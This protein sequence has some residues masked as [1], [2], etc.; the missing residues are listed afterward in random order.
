[1]RRRVLTLLVVGLMLFATACGN[2]S[3]GSTAEF[4]ATTESKSSGY[5]SLGLS[6]S[7]SEDSIGSGDYADY[8]E[9]DYESDYSNDGGSEV[10]L[11]EYDT[12]RKLIY[13]SYINLESKKFDEDVDAIKE[14]VSAN[15]G[16]FE[17]TSSYGNEEYGSRSA[18][19]TAR[20]PSDKYEAFMNS[21]GEVGSLASKS[22]SVDDIT[23]SY[24]D[25]QARLKS[26]NTKLE[27][28][29]E[30]EEQADNLED[31]LAIEDRINDVQYQIE[32]YTAQKKAYDDQIDYSTVSIDITE[33]STYSEVKADTAWNRFVE[34]FSSSFSGFV[35]FI[36]AFVIAIIYLLP[37]LILIAIILCIIFFVRKKKGKSFSFKKKDKKTDQS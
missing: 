27:R 11:S 12:S 17:S 29:Q 31:L 4:A 28:L 8:E 3:E 25:V 6:E 10:D 7:A 23:S 36:Q 1:M 32:S 18:S 16:Y 20:I 24:V 22:E 34:A 26:L 33:V 13:T 5:D 19:F 21:V 14:L 9:Q 30:L 15:G 2:A 37:Y 35:A